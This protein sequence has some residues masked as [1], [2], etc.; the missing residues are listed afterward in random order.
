MTI[1]YPVWFFLSK[2]WVGNMLMIPVIIGIPILPF[3]K[4]LNRT[5]QEIESIGIGLAILDMLL[6]APIMFG[7]LL[8]LSLH[9]E[10]Y[11]EKRGWK[12]E[13]ETGMI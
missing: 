10:E 13:M 3:Y 7:I 9:M 4:I 5:G 1:L 11:Y 12:I 2:T 6:L 8:T